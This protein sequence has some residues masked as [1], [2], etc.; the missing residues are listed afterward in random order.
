MSWALENKTLDDLVTLQRGF[1]LPSKKRI[2]GKI[3]VVASTGINGWHNKFKVRAPGVVI[4]RSGSIGGGQFITEDF[5]PLNTTLWVKDFKGNDERFAYYFLKNIDFSKFNSGSGVPT[6]NRNHIS[7][8]N[9]SIPDLP[10]QKYIA[11]VLLAYDDLI[12]NNR[13]RIALLEESARL[14]Y[15]EW[16]VHFRFPG[17]E[18]T[19]FKNGLPVGWERKAVGNLLKKLKAKPKIRKDAYQTSGQFPCVDQGQAFVGGYT[20]K[21]ASVYQDCLPLIVFGDHTRI[22]KFVN[23]PF[24]KGA[25]GTQVLLSNEE[26]LSQEMFYLALCEVDLS[27]YFYARHFKFLKEQKV[28][29]PDADTN[30]DFSEF[31]KS[32]FDQV[33]ALRKQNRTLAQARDLLLPRFMD[34]R[35]PVSL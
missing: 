26:N 11:G 23:F 31:A 25:D 3:P 16:F 14:I 28:I 20:N 32:V 21:S 8:I 18:N 10:T 33:S 22:L 6:L 19:P 2:Q 17:H 5:W 9:I 15:R 13:R 12:A 7:S 1:D 30:S 29:I 27:N 35:I 34:G 4:G 24:A